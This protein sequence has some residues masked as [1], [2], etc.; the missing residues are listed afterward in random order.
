MKIT[1]AFRVF[2]IVKLVHIVMKIFLNS[3]IF[4]IQKIVEAL[5]KIHHSNQ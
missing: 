1:L 3:N 5:P 2:L 4:F